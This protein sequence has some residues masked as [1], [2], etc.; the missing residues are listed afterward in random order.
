MP[1]SKTG[2][3][4]LAQMIAQHGAKHGTSEFYATMNKKKM[5]GKWE[6]SK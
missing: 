1:L 6:K 2:K 4:I 3:S 5:K